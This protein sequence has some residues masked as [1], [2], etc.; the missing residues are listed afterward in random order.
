MTSLNNIAEMIFL[1]L[2]LIFL[3][4]C[5][6]PTYKVTNYNNETFDCD[7]GYIEL[8]GEC[9]LDCSFGAAKKLGFVVAGTAPV[10]IE[11]IE[12]GDGKYMHH[13]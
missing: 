12:W 7:T 4:S 6:S 3:L 1:P 11:I 2:F 9:I 13:D 5:S 8:N 10:K